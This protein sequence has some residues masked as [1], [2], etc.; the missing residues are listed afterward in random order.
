MKKIL[1]TIGI[2]LC[3]PAQANWQVWDIKTGTL[4]VYSGESTESICYSGDKDGDYS[5]CYIDPNISR[6]FAK[7]GVSPNEVEIV[8]RDSIFWCGAIPKAYG[9]YEQGRAFPIPRISIYGEN[10]KNFELILLHELYHFLYPY[11]SEK[12]ADE[13]ALENY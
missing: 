1:I 10:D 11:G 9:C 4:T 5:H 12:S 7:V 6:I 3:I 13:F 2:L 8:E